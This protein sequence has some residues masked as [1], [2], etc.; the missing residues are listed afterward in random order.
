MRSKSC[1]KTSGRLSGGHPNIFMWHLGRTFLFN[2][3]LCN[4]STTLFRTHNPLS[5]LQS[6]DQSIASHYKLSDHLPKHVR[7]FA[8]GGGYIP[9]SQGSLFAAGGRHSYLWPKATRIYHMIIKYCVIF[10][11][12]GVT[13]L[14]SLF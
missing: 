14:I 9:E 13:N 5:V 3:P 6:R 8:A 4:K 10:D 11:L 2:V 12:F 7:N 1:I